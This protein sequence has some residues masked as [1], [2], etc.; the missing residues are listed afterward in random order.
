MEQLLIHLFGDYWLQ[1]D[2]MALNKTKQTLPCSVHC[3]IYTL[4]FL[5]FT[6]N[7]LALF[8]IFATHFVEDRWSLVKYFIWFKNHANPTLTYPSFD[9]CSV[10]GYYDT[11]NP[12]NK[13][14]RPNWITT[15]LYIITDNSYHLLCNFLILN[16]FERI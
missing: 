8:L 2:W 12:D 5:L 10:T 3:F 6:D 11:W 13:D 14:G 7:I 16:Y 1:S 15:W 4:P 9:K